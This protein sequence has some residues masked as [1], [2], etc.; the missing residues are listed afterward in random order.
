[1]QNDEIEKKKLKTNLGKISNFQKKRLAKNTKVFFK[2][3]T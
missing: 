3:K 1:M 2:K